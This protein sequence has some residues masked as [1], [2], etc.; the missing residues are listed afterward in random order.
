MED[1]NQNPSMVPNVGNPVEEEMIEQ[2]DLVGESVVELSNLNE[3]TVFFFKETQEK[4]H[5][6][7]CPRNLYNCAIDIRPPQDPTMCNKAII[8]VTSLRRNS[9]P[10]RRMMENDHPPTQNVNMLSATNFIIWNIRGE[11]NDDFRRNFRELMGQHRP[12]M[13]TLLETRM[14]KYVT[15]LNEFGFSKMIEI[16]AE[17]Q[18]VGMVILY[19]HAKVNVPN[20]IHKNYEIHATIEVCPIRLTWLFSSIYASINSVVRYQI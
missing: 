4:R 8:P 20:F 5:I 10:P 7:V 16:P 12:C 18:A 9:T 15:L 19:N 3:V 11:N 13:V 17:D 2:I 6:L 1:M 14:H